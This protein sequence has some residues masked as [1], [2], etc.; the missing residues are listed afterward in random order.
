MSSLHRYLTSLTKRE[1]L[2]FIKFFKTR[3]KEKSNISK[4]INLIFSYLPEETTMEVAQKDAFPNS[5][6]KNIANKFH[7]VKELVEEFFLLEKMKS[8]K[9]ERNLLLFEALLDRKFEKEANKKGKKL[10]KKLNEKSQYNQE[11]LF[12]LHRLHHL[13]FF[14]S[15]SMKHNYGEALLDASSTCLLNYSETILKQYAIEKHYRNNILK[16]LPGKSL[17]KEKIKVNSPFITLDLLFRVTS[18][19]DEHTFQIVLK[20]CKENYNK[21]GDE[22]FAFILIHLILY[23]RRRIKYTKNYNDES[24]L[25]LYELGLK[26][27]IFTL[28]GFIPEHRFGNML[29]AGFA[30]KNDKWIKQIISNYLVKLLPRDRKMMNQY[31]N[32]YILFL[33]G[34]F[35]QLS[36]ILSQIKPKSED[37]KL[38]LYWLKIMC[39]YELND[40]SALEDSLRA[41]YAYIWRNK[42]SMS[43]HMHG[44]NMAF[45]RIV[46]QLNK[47]EQRGSLKQEFE[48][49]PSIVKGSWIQEKLK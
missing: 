18:T 27:D 48:N 39:L 2:N 12:T 30:N 8:R 22:L 41:F 7:L 14:S 29:D 40:W 19:N 10:L 47:P 33:K 42:G 24:L 6:R 34:E 44:S 13:S 25:T 38:R 21:Y 31:A 16:I 36:K 32:H 11:S 37:Q 45:F 4:L 15:S 23:R 20:S 26:R 46:S 5:N 17:N 3:L 49:S 28:R 1:K 43:D 9:N 35:I